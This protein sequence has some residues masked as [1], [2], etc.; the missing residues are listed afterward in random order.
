MSVLRRKVRRDLARQRWQFV[1]VA[2]TVFLGVVLFAASYDAF[3]N[4]EASYEQTYDRL[5]FADLTITGGDSAELV[6]R[7]GD[8]DGVEAVATR[9]QADIGLRVDRAH[10]LLGRIV[11][12]PDFDQP[13]VN[14]VDVLT[15]SWPPVDDPASVL[16]ERHMAEHF[17]LEPGSQVEIRTGTLW[18]PL[19]VAATVASPEYLWPARSRQD[20]LTSSDD[21][22][23]I[24]APTAVFE[25]AVTDPT[26]QV[27]VRLAPTAD[28]GL[29]AE[30]ETEAIALGA[31]GSQLRADQPSNAALQE[32][33]SG[34]GELSFLFPLLFLGT[35][36]MATFI[37]LSRI[38]RS[39]KAQIATL[40]ANGVGMRQVVVHYLGEGLAVTT[41]AGV[42]GLLVG[43]GLGRLIT[44]VYTTAIGVPDIVTR[45][46]FTTVVI[47]LLIT[48]VAGA[49]AAA[50]P[51]VAAGRSPPAAAVRGVTPPGGG[52]LSL[53]ERLLPVLRRLPARWRMVLRG[54]GRDRRRSF[55]TAIGVVL[56][57]TLILT[58]WGMIDTVE[59]LLDRQFDQV[60]RQD[61][62]LF[63]DPAVS[64]DPSAGGLVGAIGQIEGVARVEQ[65]AQMGVVAGA[66]GRRYATELIAF[67]P[68]TR[69]HD[70]AGTGVPDGGVVAGRALESLLGVDVGDT[71][72]VAATSADVSVSLPVIGFVDE[73]LG[74]FLY[75]SIATVGAFEQR[76]E[77]M[78]AMVVFTEGV[79]R[80]V[81]RNRL[82]ALPGVVAYVDSR[83]L[84]DTAKSL[85]S[86]FYAFVA[87][88]LSFGAIMAFALLFNTATVTASERA[89]ELAALRVNGAA[90]GQLARLVAAENLLLAALAIGPGLLV[91]YRASALFMG[92]FSS[93][94]FDFDLQMRGRTL[95]FSA[96]AVMA[97]SGL[98]QW[99]AART[100]T[101][102]DVARVVRER[103]Q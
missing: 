54:I 64:L 31:A 84:Y 81:M 14:K 1:S 68:D 2:V 23:V 18:T 62:Q 82:T 29:L 25:R 38:V 99:P 93:D 42:A 75:T 30:L 27:L 88:M 63:L 13:S 94:L 28:R 3:L 100:V 77:S 5:A 8:R 19:D 22:G 90:P 11:E 17:G 57:L 65:V 61:A 43:I 72:T 67:E 32:D 15:G 36:T 76:S 44:G 37:L 4:L 70:F 48:L 58:S 47:G 6:R 78:S 96:M 39:Q 33:V 16:V 7:L 12:L 95:L 86:L 98:A 60:Q 103:S 87:V 66:N 9:R 35:A 53:I 26:T 34:F 59:I 20:V 79:D 55:S 10:A 83:A 101:S 69:M 49:A 52:G 40:R 85:L 92:S 102:L 41:V 24:F 56:A 80:A 91:G 71:I 73:P 97:A 74:T 45:F 89:P 51:A 46:H 21:F 50:A